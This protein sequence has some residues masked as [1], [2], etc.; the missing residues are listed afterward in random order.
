MSTKVVNS[1]DFVRIRH[2]GNVG[3]GYVYDNGS[4]DEPWLA[5]GI[6][7]AK[8]G[9]SN[10]SVKDALDSGA[11]FEHIIEASSTWE[12][13]HTPFVDEWGNTDWRDTGEMGK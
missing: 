11:T 3:V 10:T 12:R 4:I 7:W 9:T 13:K 8:G 5:I 1:G 2:N 6:S